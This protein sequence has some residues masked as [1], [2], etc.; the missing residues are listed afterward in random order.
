MLAGGSYLDLGLVFGTGSTYPYAIFRKVILDWICHD[1]LVDLSG[2][3]YCKDDDRMRSVANDFADRS[4]NLFS[5]CIGALDGWIVKIKKPSKR[6][7]VKDPKSFYSRKG[8]Y[9]ISVQ[10]IVDSK[11][12]VIFRSIESRGA[13]HDS[14]A[15]KRT[16]L[17]KWIMDH[18]DMLKSKRYFFIGDSAYALRSFLISFDLLHLTCQFLFTNFNHS[19]RGFDLFI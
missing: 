12:R 17:Y 1:W 6:D 3:R 15:F 18:W 7:E 16:G 14:T 19:P 2:I 5:G 4:R 9:G 10:A 11:K 13:E 8:F